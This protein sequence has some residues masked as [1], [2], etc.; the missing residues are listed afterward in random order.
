L[1]FDTTYKSL[2]LARDSQGNI[3]F[4]NTGVVLEKMTLLTDEFSIAVVPF[5]TKDPGG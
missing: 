3:V 1:R 2:L 5:L 4:P